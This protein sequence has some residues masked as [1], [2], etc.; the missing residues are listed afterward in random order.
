MQYP[1]EPLKTETTTTPIPISRTLANLL[2]AHVGRVPS[3]HVLTGE[4]GESGW[5]L[6]SWVGA[7]YP[8]GSGTTTLRHFFASLWPDSDEATRTAVEAV[9]VARADSL[10]TQEV[11]I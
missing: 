1:A 11:I 10:R 8:R 7:R 6:G 5:Q 4:A 2:A 9:L 3:E